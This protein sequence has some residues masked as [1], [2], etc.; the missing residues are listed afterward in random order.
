MIATAGSLPF[1][2]A[3]SNPWAYNPLA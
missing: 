1:P 3:A 2:Y